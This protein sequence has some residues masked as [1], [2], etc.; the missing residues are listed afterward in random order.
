MK[1]KKNS[2]KQSLI[3]VKKTLILQD[4]E[5]IKTKKA[6]NEILTENTSIKKAGEYKVL[7]SAYKN[8]INVITNILDNIEDEQI[9][10][11]ANVI[12]TTRI[13]ENR[14]KN[15]IKEPIKK[16]ES[17]KNPDIKNTFNG[18]KIKSDFFNESI[19]NNNLNIRKSPLKLSLNWKS[20]KYLPNNNNN[21]IN[22][23]YNTEL[24][25]NEN[26]SSNL[27]SSRSKNDQSN[28]TLIK[29]IYKKFGHNNNN[30]Y[31][32]PKNKLQKAKSRFNTTY[33]NS[34]KKPINNKNS[35]D[36]INKRLNKFSSSSLSSNETN[37]YNIKPSL[38]LHSRK[39]L[40]TFKIDNA[41]DNRIDSSNSNEILNIKENNCKNNTILSPFSSVD[42]KIKS[43]IEE[44]ISQDMWKM[45]NN[46]N[47]LE[48]SLTDEILN[49]K[50][51]TSK[52]KT[53]E[54]GSSKTINLKYLK[55]N[56]NKVNN[57]EKNI[58]AY[59][60]KA[61]CMIHLMMKKNLMKK[62]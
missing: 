37:I 62:I 20:N 17:Y 5:D 8:V 33:D 21:N 30:L 42:V 56:S 7:R 28:Q 50:K 18:H 54:S 48:I 47:D 11:K 53:V 46:E 60:V 59:F 9:N 36:T 38:I 25:T 40:N 61:M 16:M 34:L 22:N 27:S 19:Y 49:T 4:I 1:N 41:L 51:R 58:D 3:Q 2:L 29:K 55:G 23:I 14:N 35:L 12:G 15:K 32:K 10:G 31:F 43:E 26:I 52:L 6:K 39:E 13:L 44:K 45:K 24:N 57:K